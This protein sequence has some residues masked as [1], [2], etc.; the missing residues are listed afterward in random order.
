MAGS[1]P[2]WVCRG[3]VSALETVLFL[4]VLLVALT[5]GP[6]T[7]SGFRW[8]LLDFASESWYLLVYGGFSESTVVVGSCV[9]S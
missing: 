7:A 9:A 8:L 5:A 2:Y 4:F 3:F 1:V 6:G